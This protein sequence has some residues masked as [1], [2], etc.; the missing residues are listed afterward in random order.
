MYTIYKIKNNIT[1]K[2]YVGYTNQTPPE[3]R[4]K[5][6]IK[7]TKR[8]SDSLLH[9][10]MRKYGVLNFSFEVLE[11]G[12]DEKYGL[13]VREQFH[14]NEQK[15]YYLDGDGYN[16]TKGGEGNLGW[17]PSQETREKIRISNTG[18]KASIEAREKMSKRWKGVP[19]GPR[20]EAHNK[21]IIE[22]GKCFQPGRIPWNK[23][24]IGA[25]IA[26]N[27]GKP[28]PKIMCPHCNVTGGSPGIYKYH[29][30]NCKHK[31]EYSCVIEN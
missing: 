17:V 24:L 13:K 28:Q 21:K 6:H 14:I 7:L 12:D 10:S 16:M 27:K 19:R 23:G 1:G 29:F 25:Q 18:K 8:G 26:W 9:R 15:T 11:Q 31:Q 5:E 3:M 2:S 20:S 22:A 30:N 4:F